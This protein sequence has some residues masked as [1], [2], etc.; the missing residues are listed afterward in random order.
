MVEYIYRKCNKLESENSYKEQKLISNEHKL[1]IWNI[2]NKNDPDKWLSKSRRFVQIYKPKGVNPQDYRYCMIIETADGTLNYLERLKCENLIKS[3][4]RASFGIPG[5]LLENLNSRIQKISIIDTQVEEIPKTDEHSSKIKLLKTR[6]GDYATF[7]AFPSS[8]IQKNNKNRK[9]I[10]FN[11]KLNLNRMTWGKTSLMWTLWKSKFGTNPSQ[12]RILEVIINEE[13]MEEIMNTLKS[14]F[15]QGK[16]NNFPLIYQYDPDRRISE[17]FW[18]EGK[19]DPFVKGGKTLHLGFRNEAL[20]M[21]LLNRYR[22]IKDISKIIQTTKIKKPSNLED[23][24]Y[25][26]LN[27]EE[28]VLN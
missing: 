5:Y 20:Q 11:D 9:K 14:S 1:S 27:L 15:N 4:P 7:I 21:Y 16:F 10:N 12:E 23:Y 25:S 18:N 17:E 28:I 26:R 3:G 24:L 13:E 19:E 8:I 6:S 2:H 22:C